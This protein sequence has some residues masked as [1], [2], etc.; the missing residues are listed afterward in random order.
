ML[1]RRRYLRE[2]AS[3]FV[4]DYPHAD[5]DSIIEPDYARR[6]YFVYATP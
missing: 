4:A 3:W 1:I 2:A 5:D 6:D